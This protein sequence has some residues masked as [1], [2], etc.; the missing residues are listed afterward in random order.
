MC[1]IEQN[2]SLNPGR[3]QPFLTFRV[4]LP[5]KRGKLA[6]KQLRRHQFQWKGRTLKLICVS[7]LIPA[8]R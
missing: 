4:K 3:Q 5:Q 6:A 7:I 1:A 8:Q 2:T